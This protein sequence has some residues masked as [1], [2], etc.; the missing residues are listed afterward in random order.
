M[1]NKP[2]QRF[3][4]FAAPLV[5]VEQLERLCAISGEGRSALIKRLISEAHSKIVRSKKTT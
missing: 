4:S 5:I 3:L 2:R 1:T